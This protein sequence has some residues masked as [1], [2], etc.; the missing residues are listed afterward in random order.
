MNGNSGTPYVNIS[1]AT[2]ASVLRIMSRHSSFGV[3]EAPK[4]AAIDAV[5]EGRVYEAPKNWG[6]CFIAFPGNAE[7]GV[8]TSGWHID[9][10]YTSPLWP[11]GGVKTHALFGD[12]A[13]RGGGTQIVSGSHRFVHKWFRENPPPTGATSATGYANP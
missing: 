11:T 4:N 1:L 2:R 9:A 12:I 10:N 7:W 5:L 13:P 8:P 3:Y 6:A